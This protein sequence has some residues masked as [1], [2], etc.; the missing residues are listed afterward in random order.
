MVS[1]HDEVHD[2]N[3]DYEPLPLT[4]FRQSLPLFLFYDLI[5][6]G[7]QHACVGFPL[8]FS[9]LL[10]SIDVYCL[11]FTYS[12]YFTNI[13]IVD[14][15]HLVMMTPLLSL[16]IHIFAVCVA[17]PPVNLPPILWIQLTIFRN[18][19]LVFAVVIY[20]LW[21]VSFYFSG[22][23]LDLIREIQITILSILHECIQCQ[24][25]FFIWWHWIQFS[26]GN[27]YLVLVQCCCRELFRHNIFF[28]IISL[29]TGFLYLKNYKSEA[30]YMS[31]TGW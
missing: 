22:S 23:C 2:T 28:V 7:D 30:I 31:W 18:L 21:L 25:L 16:F 11:V 12:T 9:T 8:Y 13:Q 1:G 26:W 19:N 5:E 15:P 14:V 29:L 4:Y 27:L 3:H 24:Y 10:L 6:N 20:W 17:F